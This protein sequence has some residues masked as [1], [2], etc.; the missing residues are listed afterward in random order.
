ML[1]LLLPLLPIIIYTCS[2]LSHLKCKAKPSLNIAGFHSIHCT[3]PSGSAMFPEKVGCAHLCH[4]SPSSAHFSLASVLIATPML[5][6]PSGQ[7]WQ[8][9][10][11]LIFSN[12]TQQHL[13]RNALAVAPPESLRAQ[14]LLPPGP[15]LCLHLAFLACC[16]L[17]HQH[18]A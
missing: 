9:A 18:S 17:F 6:F 14:L 15:L 2:C 1:L 7:S 3:L 10:L 5:H 16:L 4:S 11:R 8:A 13:K 12:R